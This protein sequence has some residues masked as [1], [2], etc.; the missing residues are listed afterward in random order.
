M[1]RQVLIC[2][3][4]VTVPLALGWTEI[5]RNMFEFNITI[6]LL[7]ML[8]IAKNFRTGVINENDVIVMDVRLIRNHYLKRW[9]VSLATDRPTTVRSHSSAR[10]GVGFNVVG[11]I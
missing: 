8:D 6:D 3:T 9:C 1:R 5:N 2:I 11:G 7:F 4:V 10:G